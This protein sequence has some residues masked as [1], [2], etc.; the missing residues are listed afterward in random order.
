VETY[1][2]YALAGTAQNP[3]N[4]QNLV[5]IIGSNSYDIIQGIQNM[6]LLQNNIGCVASLPALVPPS[7][8]PRG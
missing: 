7:L 2:L 4:V 8:R 1:V 5:I 3:G 6:P